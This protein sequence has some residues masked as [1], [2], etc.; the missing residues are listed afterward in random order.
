MSLV[1]E[2]RHAFLQSSSSPHGHELAR[3]LCQL[4]YIYT[5]ISHS[6]QYITCIGINRSSH[7]M[8]LHPKR[9]S[10]TILVI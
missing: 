10:R 5:Y 1:Q 8:N 9:F 6:G 4:L 2:T 3:V 7:V